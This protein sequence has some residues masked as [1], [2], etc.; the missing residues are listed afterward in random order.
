MRLLNR[1]NRIPNPSVA[2][3]QS[4]GLISITEYSIKEIDIEICYGKRQLVKE[5][6]YYEIEIPKVIS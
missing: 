1:V 6:D 5:L 4:L 2:M 3:L